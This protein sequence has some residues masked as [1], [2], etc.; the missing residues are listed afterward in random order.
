MPSQRA[1]PERGSSLQVSGLSYMIKMLL[2]ECPLDTVDYR[3][4]QCA[5]FNNKRVGIHGLPA[6]NR[7][8]PKYSGSKQFLVTRL[9][10]G[11][12]VV[13]L[14]SQC[15]RTV[16]ALLSGCRKRSILYAERQSGGRDGLWTI[17]GRYVRGWSVQGKCNGFLGHVGF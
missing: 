10:G 8:V 11:V 5:E 1:W 17:R 12:N 6:D 7:W 2:Q 3:E 16:Q 4:V 14:F 9:E 15:E 13:Y